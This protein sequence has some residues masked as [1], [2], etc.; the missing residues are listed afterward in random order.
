MYFQGSPDLDAAAKVAKFIGSRHF[1]F[2]FTVQEGL[3]ALQAPNQNK[4]TENDNHYIIIVL[5]EKLLLS[6]IFFENNVLLQSD[7]VFDSEA[8]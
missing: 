4:Q 8:L 1:S 3:D 7:A 2:E 6:V 5:N